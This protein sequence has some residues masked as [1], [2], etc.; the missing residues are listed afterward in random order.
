MENNA[1]NAPPDAKAPTVHV[2]TN[3]FHAIAKPPDM[4]LFPVNPAGGIKIASSFVSSFRYTCTFVFAGFFLRFGRFDSS[5][6]D[7]VV[8]NP[9]APKVVRP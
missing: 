5:S 1:K 6:E 7:I 3:A 4:A 8:L 9:G 2:A